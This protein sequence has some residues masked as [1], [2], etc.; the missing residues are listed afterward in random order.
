MNTNLTE[1]QLEIVAASGKLLTNYGVSGLTIKNLAKEVRFSESAIYRH[2]ASKED[3]ML[4]MLNYLAA[5]MHKILNDAV[6]SST[7]P[8]VQLTTL[9]H[10]QF[11]FFIEN[12]HF[13]SVVYL[14]GL[15]EESKGINET[16]HKILMV[17]VENF[18][19]VVKAGQQQGVFT[20]VISTDELIHIMIGAARLEMYKWRVSNF[21]FDLMKNGDIMIQ[22]LLTL[23]KT[24]QMTDLAAYAAK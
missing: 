15:M 3:I 9:F 10:N 8:A 6:L 12:K 19:P 4:A 24:E 20:N 11:A 2:F 18:A 16:I 21:Q 23:I 22:T 14:D 7:I 17:Q 1:R 13:V 5:C